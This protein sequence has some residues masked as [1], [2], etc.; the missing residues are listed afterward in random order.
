MGI[1]LQDVR[2]HMLLHP[3]VLHGIGLWCVANGLPQ[4]S[5]FG[6]G[7]CSMSPA[8]RR[9]KRGSNAGFLPSL[10]KNPGTW[11]FEMVQVV[12]SGLELMPGA[13]KTIPSL[14]SVFVAPEIL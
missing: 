10:H 6:P 4:V 3:A 2:W 9:I 7:F 8:C 12:E 14:M 5:Q 13:Y 1:P 11:L